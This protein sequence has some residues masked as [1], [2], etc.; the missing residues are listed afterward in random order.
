MP[1]FYIFEI[2]WLIKFNG[3]KPNEN[4][5][6]CDKTACF[7]LKNCLKFMNFSKLPCSSA[8]TLPR[9]FNSGGGVKH[10]SNKSGYFA[11]CLFGTRP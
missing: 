2:C 8:T 3:K 11:M 5:C 1:K 4:I 6:N 10:I 9:F 7:F